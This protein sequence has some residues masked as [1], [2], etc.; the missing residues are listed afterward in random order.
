[1]GNYKDATQ[2][3]ERL[4]R[5]FEKLNGDQRALLA[6]T[7]LAALAA[8]APAK[9]WDSCLLASV[10][11]LAEFEATVSASASVN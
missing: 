3:M 6:F 5:A 10:S 7:F 1:M 9:A 11:A 8:V 4:N 2:N